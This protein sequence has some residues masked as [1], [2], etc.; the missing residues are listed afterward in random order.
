MSFVLTKRKVAAVLAGVAVFSIVQLSA[1]TL[2]GATSDTLQAN[3]ASVQDNK[4]VN[5]Q[6][7]VAYDANA[8]SNAATSD[9]ANSSSKGSFVV[10]KVTVTFNQA[11]SKDGVVSVVLS[12]ANGGNPLGAGVLTSDVKA[13]A[14][15]ADFTLTTPVNVENIHQVSVALNGSAAEVLAVKQG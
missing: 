12:D 2:G 10:D 4:G 8:V 15:T 14:T 3:T 6:Y 11:V 7:H 1:A 9:S 5:V 13:G